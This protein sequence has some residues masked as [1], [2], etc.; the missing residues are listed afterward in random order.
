[1]TRG[2]RATERL[3]WCQRLVC[4]RERL[5]P[6]SVLDLRPLPGPCYLK[7]MVSIGARAYLLAIG[8]FLAGVAHADDGDD[9]P[10]PTGNDRVVR[11]VDTLRTSESFKVRAT[12][13]VAL[14]RIGDARASPAL[15]RALSSDENYVVR[16]AAASALAKL[17]VPDS[18][19]ALLTALGDSDAFV[20]E[21]AVTSLEHF[22]TPAFAAAFRDALASDDSLRR[23]AAVRALADLARAGDTTSGIAVLRATTDDDGRVALTA[24]RTIGELPADRAIPVLVDGLAN[25]SPPIR[26]SSARGLS[27]RP[28]A[29]SVPVLVSVATSTSETEDVRVAAREALRAHRSYVDVAAAQTSATDV[30]PANRDTRTTSLRLLGALGEASAYEAVARAMGDAD[31]VVRLAAA[32]AL[33]DFGGARAKAALDAARQKEPDPRAQRQLELLAKQMHTEADR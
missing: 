6:D 12:A 24:E 15:T 4:R 26:L 17:P 28:S 23:L 25:G 30:T 9:A 2:R 29:A 32:R 19:A 8:M 10:I 7:K 33:V 31:G 13:A 11:L 14:G 1:M 22:H 3:G 18:A 16:V 21:E 5:A 27:R 20:R